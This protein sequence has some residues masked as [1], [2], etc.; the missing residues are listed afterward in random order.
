MV[1][2]ATVDGV[3]CGLGCIPSQFTRGSGL[4]NVINSDKGRDLAANDF[5]ALCTILCDFS[6]VLVYVGS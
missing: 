5:D 3:E 1:R 2:E 4:T 6:R